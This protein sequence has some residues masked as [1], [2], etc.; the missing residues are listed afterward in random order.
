MFKKAF[1]TLSLTASMAISVMAGD[2]IN[3]AGATFPAP[4]YYDWAHAY[5]A[6]TGTQINYQSIGSGGGVKQIQGRTVDFGA[7]DEPMKPDEL[8]KNNLLQFPAAVGAIGIAYNLPGV[9]VSLKLSNSVVSDI[10]LG[11]ITKWNDPRIAKDNAGVALPDKVIT[12]VHRSD[13]SGT[14][15]N[16]S[17]W[18]SQM[19][20]E[21]K[22]KVGFGKSLRWPTGLGGKGNEGCSNIVKQSPGTI[23]YLESAYIKKNGLF[24]ATVQSKEGS[25]VVLDTKSAKDATAKATWTTADHFY[26]ILTLMP[27]KNSYPIT[28]GTFILLP[29]EKVEQN[30]KIV[31]FF[32]YAFKEGDVNAEKLGYI[33]LPDETTKLV[34]SYW[35]AN[36]L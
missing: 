15:F 27:G 35:K 18:L 17:Y 34:E 6:K 25:W 5:N 14:T 10:F 9:A 30:K 11:K 8:A 22:G 19:N 23:T 13:G 33:P 20:P 3:G 28:A 7:T 2:K 1:V 21:W 12:V 29:K 36:G 24:A 26:E 16:F 32:R 4:L 31:T